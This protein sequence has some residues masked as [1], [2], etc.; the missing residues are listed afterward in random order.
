MALGLIGRDV[1]IQ[2]LDAILDATVDRGDALLVSG[3]PGIGKTSLLEAVVRRARS[4][5]Y[6]VLTVAGLQS[7]RELP[8]AGLHQLL[9]PV[10]GVA[11]SLAAPQRS[12][13]LTA[14]GM[15]EGAPPE[16][17]LVALATLNLLDKV[18]DEDPLVVV[19][20]DVH[21]LDAATTSVLAFLARRLEST[22]I[23]VVL[24]L[25]QGP[26]TS[27]TSAH[28]REIHLEPL[29]EAASARLVDATAPDLDHHSRRL[30]FDEA[31]GNPLALVELPQAFRR[32]GSDGREGALRTV[33]LSERL[34]RT[35]SAEAAM[36]PKQTQAVLLYA[37]L[38]SDCSVDDLLRT[39]REGAGDEVTVDV[40][41]PALDAGLIS[42]VGSVVRFR[43]PLIRSALDQSAAV[44][45]RR[46]AH[47]VLAR[48]VAD[49]D[50]RAWHRAKAAL[51]PD[52]DA[53]TDLD[54]VA[55]RARD[56]GATA[57]A[58]GALELAASLTPDES[59]RARRL[60]A[61]AELAF[62]LGDR[63]AVS[64]LVDAA[65]ALRLTSHDAARVTWLREIFYDGEPG[66]ASA[67]GH[68][69]AAARA[70]E[71]AGDVCLSLNLLHGAAL[72][73]WW[74]DPGTDAKDLVRNAVEELAGDRE[75]PLALEILAMVEPIASA[76]R[77]SA[78]VREAAAADGPD[79]SRN[80]LLAFAAFAV[81]D[82]AQAIEL[83]DRAAPALRAQGR[84]GVLAQLLVMRAT[85]A[86]NTGDFS[87]ATETA[88]EANRLAT[89]TEQPI[90]V[91][92]SQIWRAV[93]VGL[94]GDEPAAEAQI[95]TAVEEFGG[96]RLI[97]LDLA[98]FARA[99]IALTAGRHE[100]A[101]ELLSPPFLPGGLA[102]RRLP[103]HSAAPF[104][105]ESAV[106]SG[107]INDAR[108]AMEVLEALAER[109]ASPLLEIGVRFG[110]ALLA[111][112]SNAEGLYETALVE[113]E[114]WPFHH[115]RLE[116]S[117]G[118]WLRRQR[119][120]AHSRPHLRAARDAFNELGA[121]PWA[122]MARVE[123]R[124]AGAR[125]AE[126]V[127]ALRQPLTPQE[128]QIARMAAYGHSNREIANQLFLSHR[129]VG[130]H[131]YRVFPKLGIVSR[132][133]LA[134]A[135]ST[136]EPPLQREG[137]QR[138]IRSSAT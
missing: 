9:Q 27:L 63:P 101:W 24:A 110:R 136:I 25:R 87:R 30:V 134:Q 69:V 28:L 16:M 83:L 21:W 22:H 49:P 66:L 47:L 128:L 7:E 103:A 97:V 114:R 107:R 58:L 123:L 112:D 119:R 72:R 100:A 116:L 41:Q 135:L 109:T 36:L 90:W 56:R 18:S 38:D 124:A 5:G 113:S 120:I 48:I 20:D 78:R 89:E 75:A 111:E 55:T 67:I 50:R 79:P 137:T 104:L 23:V 14:L 76:A 99:L 33:P 71:Q 2:L 70:A 3:E 84:L 94:H 130:A 59:H 80:Q 106:R 42:I 12:A 64:R 53:A 133:E 61:A 32:L 77:I 44:A 6:R 98:D 54:A 105:I 88:D 60:L 81:G 35:F 125:D 13:L 10:L 39:A 92:I 43:H 138:E 34:E 74:A 40:L 82:Y 11:G 1:E 37:A 132:S 121:Q 17:F 117:Y 68:L 118:T 73:C 126:P 4:H 15:R 51:G 102:F 52:E 122:D 108:R 46:N 96:P 31:R 8:Y 29:S 91:A 85:A 19:A 131:L 93:L 115:A 86:V 129:T 127:P 65:G 57:S 95:A 62:Q 26:P 45:Q